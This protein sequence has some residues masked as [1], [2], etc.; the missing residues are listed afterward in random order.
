MLLLLALAS[1]VRASGSSIFASHCAVCHQP[2]G[3]G[4]PGT[5]PPLADSIGSYLRVPEGRA[6]LV[7]VVSFGLTGPISV[8]GYFYYGVMQSWSQFSDEQVADVLNYVLTNFNPGLLPKDFKPY[9]ADEVRTLRAARLQFADV[10]RERAALQK[11]LSKAG[12]A[13]TERKAPAS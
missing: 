6:Y 11:A 8:H 10:Y 9:T 1:S 4:V 3:K 2:S 12:S 13:T 5:Y 7:H